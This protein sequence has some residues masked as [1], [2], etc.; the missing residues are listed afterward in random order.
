[1]QQW[2]TEMNIDYRQDSRWGW[3]PAGWQV[4]GMMADGSRR[5]VTVATVT[6]YGINV[7]IGAREFR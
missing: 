2:I 6:S 7:P 1:V 3:V 5:L 4:I